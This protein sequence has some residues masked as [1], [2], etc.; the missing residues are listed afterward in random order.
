M[1]SYLEASFLLWLRQHRIPEPQ[2]QFRFNQTRRWK[3]DFAWT[4]SKFAVEVEGMGRK[5]GGP[6]SHRTRAGFL[7]D[8][9][10]YE[11]AMRLGWTVYRVPGPWIANSKRHIWR[12]ET[13]ETI[14]IMLGFKPKP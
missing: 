6:S 1:Q 2:Q 14:K 10:K 12:A 4:A 8:C 5:D 9:A 3:F 7:K 11:S 13:L